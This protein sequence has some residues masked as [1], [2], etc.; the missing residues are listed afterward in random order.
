[1][2]ARPCQR[3]RGAGGLDDARPFMAQ[4][5]WQRV[6]QRALD[7]FQVGVTETAGTKTYQDIV[8]AKGAERDALDGE[9]PAYLVQDGGAKVHDAAA[10]PTGTAPPPCLGRG[11]R[12]AAS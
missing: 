10:P 5:D 1:M 8:R 12:P 6:G 2:I 7:D 11:S 3:H 9:R 4:D